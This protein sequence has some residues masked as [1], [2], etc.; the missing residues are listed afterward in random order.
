MSPFLQGVLIGG[1]IS[2]AGFIAAS[3]VRLMIEK[4]IGTR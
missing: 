2:I 3:I 4:K 1:V